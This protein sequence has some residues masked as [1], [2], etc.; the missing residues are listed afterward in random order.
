[1]SAPYE[2]FAFTPK[3]KPVVPVDLIRPE[4]PGEKA[5]KRLCPS[6]HQV[7]ISQDEN[8]HNEISLKGNIILDD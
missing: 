8:M 2:I 5:P 7:Y 4:R 3:D 1:L 6:F